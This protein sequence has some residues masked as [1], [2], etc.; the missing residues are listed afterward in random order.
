[1]IPALPILLERGFRFRSFEAY[2]RCVGVQRDNF[3]ALVETTP[4]GGLRLFGTSGYLIGERI[5]MLVERGGQ[6]VFESKGERI[7][8]SPEMLEAFQ[9]FQRDLRATLETQL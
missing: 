5:A 4:Q 3:V 8:A 2:P 9:R 7:P 1:M 6:S